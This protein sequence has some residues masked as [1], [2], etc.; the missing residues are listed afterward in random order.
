MVCEAAIPQEE[1]RDSTSEKTARSGVSE[2]VSSDIPLCSQK[3]GGRKAFSLMTADKKISLSV[4]SSL[5]L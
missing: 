5:R 3:R 1:D 4:A 2:D